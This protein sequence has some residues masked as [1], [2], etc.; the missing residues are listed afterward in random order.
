MVK[1]GALYYAVFVAFVIILISGFLFLSS[2]LTRQN[3]NYYIE[4]D[5]LR[6]NINSGY[7]LIK[8]NFN[9]VSSGNFRNITLFGNEKVNIQKRYWGLYYILEIESKWKNLEEKSISLAGLNV[10]KTEKI[11]LYLADFNNS[12]SLCGNTFIRGL[13]YLPKQQVK[14]AY[15]EGKSFMGSNLINGKQKIS[16][17]TLPAYNSILINENQSLLNGKFNTNDS[18]VLYDK[19]PVAKKYENS[20]YNKTAI[21]YATAKKQSI[22]KNFSGNIILFSNN[23]F[24]IDSDAKLNDVIIYARKVIVENGFAGRIQIFAKDTII[25]E[26]NCNLLFPSAIALYN[27]NNKPVYFLIGNNSELFGDLFVYSN[28]TA[29]RKLSTLEINKESKIMGQVYSNVTVIHK[30]KIYGSL[31]ANKFLLKTLSS[32]Y[33]NHLLDA[34]IDFQRLD[35]HFVCTGLMDNTNKAKIIKYLE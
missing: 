6:A 8:N 7:I 21:I 9:L 15:I 29:D 33:E 1:A 11:A 17:P 25:T 18:I 13:C 23:E 22:D 31:Y 3:I 14:R 28:E 35:K 2:Y 34:T 32:V 26:N 24:I 20:F 4:K 30:G 12:L 10:F 5:Q 27:T 16:K 19:L